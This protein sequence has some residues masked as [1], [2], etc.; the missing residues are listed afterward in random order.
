MEG[1]A[2]AAQ[3]YA[4]EI[5]GQRYIE[6]EKE[7]RVS[8]CREREVEGGQHGLCA[9]N[10]RG[11]GIWDSAK[12]QEWLLIAVYKLPERKGGAAVGASPTQRDWSAG[13]KLHVGEMGRELRSC[14]MTGRRLI[15]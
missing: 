1:I 15:F 3:I 6:M 13:T 11:L 12:R 8:V 10:A 9:M 5:R 7:A 2:R 4:Q 14:T